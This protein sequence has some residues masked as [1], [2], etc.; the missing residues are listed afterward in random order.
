MRFLQWHQKA[1]LWEHWATSSRF[2]NHFAFYLVFTMRTP[3]HMMTHCSHSKFKTEL[4]IKCCVLM[5]HRSHSK[6]KTKMKIKCFDLV[7]NVI[8]ILLYFLLLFFY[9]ILFLFFDLFYS[10]TFLFCS[11]FLIFLFN[12]ELF[13]SYCSVFFLRLCYF[14][15]MS[16]SLLKNIMYINMIF[17]W[18]CWATILW[19]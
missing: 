3:G 12:F 15:F 10:H 8:F 13:F 14:Y 4:K 16:S 17:L 6:L 9:F 5:A 7:F 1:V 11:M 18:E 19:S 2:E